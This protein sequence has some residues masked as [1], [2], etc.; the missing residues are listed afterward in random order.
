MTID[1]THG[2]KLSNETH[3]EPAPSQEDK[4]TDRLVTHFIVGEAA[5]VVW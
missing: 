2:C 4:G 1:I 3:C 5:I